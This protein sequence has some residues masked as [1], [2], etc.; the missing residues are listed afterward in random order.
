[1]WPA[2]QF[3]TNVDVGKKDKGTKN[4]STIALRY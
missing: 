2:T 4:W 1:M 3:N